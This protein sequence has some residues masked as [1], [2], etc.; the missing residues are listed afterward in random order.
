VDNAATTT[1]HLDE[2]M[3]HLD[4]CIFIGNFGR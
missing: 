1:T 4:N 2:C 3:D